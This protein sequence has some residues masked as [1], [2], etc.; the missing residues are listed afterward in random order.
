MDYIQQKYMMTMQG[1]REEKMKEFQMVKAEDY[2]QTHN[3]LVV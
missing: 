2:M 1:K 3:L